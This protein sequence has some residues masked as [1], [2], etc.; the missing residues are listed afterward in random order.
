MGGIPERGTAR[1][2]AYRQLQTHRGEELCRP[3]DREILDPAALDPPDPRSVDPEGCG[4]R[5]LAETPIAPGE[6]ELAGD[7]MDRLSTAEPA[8]LDDGR[9]PGH[10]R[11]SIAPLAHHGLSRSGGRTRDGRRGSGAVA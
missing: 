5:S 11:A 7:E 6:P 9:T 2:G 8:S 10:Y 1:V 4:D 3:Y